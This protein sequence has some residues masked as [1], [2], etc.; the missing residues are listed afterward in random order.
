MRRLVE[1]KILLCTLKAGS[2]E[3]AVKLADKYEE[4]SD[5]SPYC[6]YARAALAYQSG[7]EAKAEGWLAMASRVFGRPEILSPWQDTM[8][9]FGYIKSFYGSDDD[10][11][12]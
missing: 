8:I 11:N 4:I 6:Y 1:F 3:D 12:S 10:A 7:D 5:D 2:K 9:E